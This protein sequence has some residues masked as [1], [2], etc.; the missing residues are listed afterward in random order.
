V[1]CP[2][3]ERRFNEKAAERHIPVCTSIRSKPSSLKRGTGGGAA[4]GGKSNTQPN[5]KKR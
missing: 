3:C 5:P 4:G 1:Q 2:H